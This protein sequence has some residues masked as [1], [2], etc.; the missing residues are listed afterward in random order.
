VKAIASTCAAGL[1]ARFHGFLRRQR[2]PKAQT[3]AK[4]KDALKGFLGR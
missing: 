4:A 1:G 2:M 3:K